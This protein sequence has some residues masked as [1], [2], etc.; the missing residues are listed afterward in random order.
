MA[1]SGEAKGGV[2]P[3]LAPPRSLTSH[4]DSALGGETQTGAH[5]PRA[6]V[7]LCGTTLGHGVAAEGEA[8]GETLGAR[9]S[10]IL[11]ADRRTVTRR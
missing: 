1:G 11:L 6:D 4:R 8:Q 9:S 5:K 2:A 10:A 7:R 3:T